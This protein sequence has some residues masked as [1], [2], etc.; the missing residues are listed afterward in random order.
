[1]LY[2]P[3]K[4]RR[5]IAATEMAIMAP[6]VLTLLMG[7]WEVGR[8]IAMQN[9]LD[10]A[11]R[12]GGRLGCSG[13][14]FSS[15]NMNDS[16]APHNLIVLA[17]PSKNTACEM[18]QKVLLY[19]QSAG[20]S[21]TGATVTVANTGTGVKPKSWTYTYTTGGAISGTG[22]DPTADADQLDQLGITVTVPYKNIA[23]SPLSWFVSQ[24]TT[25]TAKASWNSM[26]DIPLT[27][28][29]SIPS[30][31]LLPTDPLP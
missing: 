1:M 15:N 14:Y 26:V 3:G 25:M 31:P 11:A 10:N 28:S 19:L 30:K 8:Y 29:T 6:V 20:V 9:L 27:V 17:S 21:T 4:S 16:V 2:R 23:W 24:S 22:Y 18:Q 7:L 5:G 12:E 13:S